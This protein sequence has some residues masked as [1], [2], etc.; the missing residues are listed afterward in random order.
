MT[1]SNKK[2]AKGFTLVEMVVSVG[3]FAVVALIGTT[4]LLSLSISQRKAISIQSAYDNLRFAVEIIAKDLRTGDFYHCGSSL[5]ID[6]PLDCSGGADNIAFINA[7]GQ[8]I[9]YRKNVVSGIGVIEK[10]VCD[11]LFGAC[12]VYD[13]VT[14]SD[15]DIQNLVFY[16]R[17]S[18]IESPAYQPIVTIIAKGLAGQGKTASQFNLQTS[19]TQRV[20]RQ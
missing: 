8:G 9:M 1:I 18:T 5:P 4:S 13:Q 11:E 17:G 16:V 19:V 7:F 3:I 12:S 14:G 6:S 10:S 15:V 20:V 2:I